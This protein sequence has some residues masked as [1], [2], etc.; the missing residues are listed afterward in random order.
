MCAED[1]LRAWLSKRN[2]EVKLT[3][4]RERLKVGGCNAAP[5]KPHLQVWCH[6][7]A[8]EMLSS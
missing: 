4:P 6:G 7:G 2:V 3:P 1:E 8:C 5:C